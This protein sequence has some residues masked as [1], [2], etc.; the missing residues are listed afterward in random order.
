VTY[1]VQVEDFIWKRHIDQLK[2]LSGTKIQPKTGEVTEDLLF[3]PSQV[4][5][6]AEPVLPKEYS[7]SPPQ[8]KDYSRS[9]AQEKLEQT[10]TKVPLPQSTSTKDFPKA[11]EPVVKSPVKPPQHYPQR[12]RKTSKRLIEEA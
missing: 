5:P 2:D 8:A 4:Q 11:K 12:V 1:R 3:Q 7:Y 6:T 10:Q 9:P